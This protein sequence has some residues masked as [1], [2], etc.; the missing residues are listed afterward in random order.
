[1]EQRKLPWEISI[2]RRLGKLKTPDNLQDILDEA[3]FQILPISLV[4]I[5]ATEKLPL[6]HKDPFDRM[7]IAQAQIEGMFLASKDGTIA[8]YQIP[9]L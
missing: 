5:D 2:K 7:L 9:I 4:H 8:E 1:M 3:G 6:I